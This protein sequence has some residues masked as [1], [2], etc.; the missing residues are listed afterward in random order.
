MMMRNNRNNGI[1]VVIMYGLIMKIILQLM[2]LGIWSIVVRA[3]TQNIRGLNEL[4]L[5]PPIPCNTGTEG[6]NCICPGN[7]LTY[8]NSTGGCHPNDCWKWDSVKAQCVESGKEY[9]PALILQGIPLTGYFGSGFGNMGR[10]DIFGIYMGVMFGGCAL[11][12]FCACCVACKV[13]NSEEIHKDN[14][15]CGK[16]ITNCNGCLLSIALTT[17]WIWGIVVIANKE[18]EAPW[19]DWKGDT[20]MC[21]LVG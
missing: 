19:T 12:C 18:V 9:L 11:I 20:I 14:T 15:E 10:W 8:Y 5:P 13:A 21:P 17:L 2:F 7:C 3:E 16:L 4:S 6:P 1:I